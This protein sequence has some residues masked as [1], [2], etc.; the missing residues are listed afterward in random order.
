M[1]RRDDEMRSDGQCKVQSLSLSFSLCPQYLAAPLSWQPPQGNRSKET[2]HTAPSADGLLR[3]SA[4]TC[5][6][7]QSPGWGGGS[8][9]GNCVIYCVCSEGLP[10]IERGPSEQPHQD[11]RCKPSLA[12]TSQVSPPTGTGSS[13]NFGAEVWRSCFCVRSLCLCVKGD[14]P[15]GLALEGF[16]PKSGGHR[17]VNKSPETW[18]E[19]C[20]PGPRQAI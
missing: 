9:E 13:A 16:M 14:L 10:Q 3:N 1:M 19:E 17:D 15:R 12:S 4:S 8:R 18:V 2:V 11:P 20:S 6:G 5:R 7:N